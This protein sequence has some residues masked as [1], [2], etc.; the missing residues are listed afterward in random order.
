MSESSP[1]QWRLNVAAVILDEADNVLLGSTPGKS[2]YWHFPQ[3]GVGKNETLRE[4]V[5]REVREEVGFE[6]QACSVIAYY[7]GL[8]Y[9]YRHKNKKSERWLGQEQTY[10]FIR[11]PGI[12]PT[13]PLAPSSGEFAALLWLPWR[14]LTG[15]LFVPFKR[16]AVIPAL[17]AFFPNGATTIADVADRLSPQRYGYEPSRSLASYP[18]VDKALFGGGKAEIAA[19]LTDLSQR[20]NTA[21]RRM[22]QGRLVVMLVGL[23]G[24][25]LT[26]ALRRLARCMDPLYTHAVQPS[27]L[28][29]DQLLENLPRAGTC[30]L[31]NV[32]PYAAVLESPSYACVD[33]IHAANHA[34]LTMRDQGVHVI[35]AFLHVSFAEHLERVDNPLSDTR[36]RELSS[37]AELMLR[38]SSAPGSP[39]WFIVPSDCR[40]Y[41]DFVLAELVASAVES[42]P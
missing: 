12:R 38:E 29:P 31:L 21:Q 23:P 4:A 28:L 8:R 40:W 10:F 35:K 6:P 41:R 24:C 42:M 17:R 16:E 30:A 39:P 20:I 19:H 9:A 11:C 36:W 32:T 7:G 14:E 5:L 25:G 13:P 34:E 18:C 3:G 1:E 15:D 26:N 22:T 2:P 37:L 27:S 33:M